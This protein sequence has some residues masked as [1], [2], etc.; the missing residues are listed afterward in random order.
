MK[1][2]PRISVQLEICILF[3]IGR[4]PI[5]NYPEQVTEYVTEMNTIDKGQRLNSILEVKVWFKSKQ[6]I[7]RGNNGGSVDGGGGLIETKD[8]EANGETD[9]PYKFSCAVSEISFSSTRVDFHPVVFTFMLITRKHLAS[10]YS[11]T[12]RRLDNMSANSE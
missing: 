1:L 8:K 10:L 7:N 12:S 5:V 2:I 6:T 11:L 3:S 4:W 9:L